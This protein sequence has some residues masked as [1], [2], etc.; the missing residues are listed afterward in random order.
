MYIS[1]C[2]QEIF[3]RISI[4]DTGKELRQKGRELF[5]IVFT[6]SRRFTTVRGSGSACTWA[7]KII[8]MQNGYIELESQAGQGSTFKIYLPNMD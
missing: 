3:T 2:R 4:K 8:T 6:G 5:S 7:R 1:V